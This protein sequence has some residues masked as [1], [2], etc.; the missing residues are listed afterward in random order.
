MTQAALA[1]F[2]DEGYLSRHLR[3]MRRVYAGRRIHF[4]AEFEKYLSPW[5]ELGRTDSG[6]QLVGFLRGKWLDKTV[7]TAARGHD[8]N[9]SPLSMQY[10][11]K[12][13]RQGLLMGFA[14]VDEALCTKAM[15]D[16][17]LALTKFK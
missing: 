9:V 3:H 17:K 1:D 11:F 8:V 10:R 5:M 4:M 6:I 7:A 2:I 16:L 13:A 12:P 15:K 14:A